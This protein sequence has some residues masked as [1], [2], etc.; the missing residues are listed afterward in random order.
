MADPT[1]RVN[2]M[3]TGVVPI[4]AATLSQIT[5]LSAGSADLV[6]GWRPQYTASWSPTTGN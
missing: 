1:R 2:G 4:L 5:M 3:G 6:T